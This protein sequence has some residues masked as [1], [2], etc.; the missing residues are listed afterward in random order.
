MRGKQ[1]SISEWSEH[2]TLNLKVD[3]L[4]QLTALGFIF[5]SQEQE[6][7]SSPVN[8]KQATVGTETGHISFIY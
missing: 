5:V 8:Q 2:W 6:T 4:Q 3:G 7:V 1:K